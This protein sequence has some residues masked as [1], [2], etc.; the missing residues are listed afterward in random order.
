[1][2]SFQK[3]NPA[4]AGF[5]LV[6]V[7]LALGILAFALVP[8]LG[9]VANGLGSV[10]AAMNTSVMAEIAQ[11]VRA[12]LGKLN[13][14]ALDTQLKQTLYFDNEGALVATETGGNVV[15]STAASVYRAVVEKPSRP[16]VGIFS[17]QT[18]SSQIYQV[19]VIASYAP[20]N[21]AAQTVNLVKSTMLITPI[22]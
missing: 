18:A 15:G 21:S 9:M 8:M 5:S 19:E 2:D 14:T 10:R 12:R 16:N 6:E 4:Q 3:T 22:N 17:G 1:M 7:T 20:G 13:S 11:Q